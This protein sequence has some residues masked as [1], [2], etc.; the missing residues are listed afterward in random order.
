[1]TTVRRH[2]CGLL[3]SPFDDRHVLR[4]VGHDVLDPG[5]LT[6][7]TSLDH[8]LHVVLVL[9][10]G[11][12]GSRLHV[13][14][15]DDCY[16]MVDCFLLIG[17]PGRVNDVLF[18]TSHLNLNSLLFTYWQCQ[19]QLLLQN[20]KSLFN[21]LLF[22]P[23]SRQNQDLVTTI[24]NSYVQLVDPQIYLKTRGNTLKTKFSRCYPRLVNVKNGQGFPT[25]YG[26]RGKWKSIK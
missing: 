21:R 4:P 25:N 6:S 16:N 11:K 9:L 20:E 24:L 19:S 26:R 2:Y 15:A 10:F 12:G 5:P 1:M 18:L 3:H 8:S 14:V 7:T 22:R 17:V 23:P 13:V